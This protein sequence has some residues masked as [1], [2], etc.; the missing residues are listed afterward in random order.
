M[1]NLFFVAYGI[2]RQ[3]EEMKNQ[4]SSLKF[5]LKWKDPPTG[6]EVS[7][8][9]EGNLQPVQ[10]FKFSFPEDQLDTVLRT[11][12]FNNISSHHDNLNKYFWL[13]RKA[14]RLEELPEYNKEGS[15]YPLVKDSFP[16]VNLTAIGYSKDLRSSDEN[17]NELL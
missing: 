12:K 5:P 8:F 11:L 1:T 15:Y 4:L 9:I 6:K 13:L 17:N 16:N 14:L 2:N 10:L 7:G 3:I